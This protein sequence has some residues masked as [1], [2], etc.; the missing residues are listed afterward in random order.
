MENDFWV[1]VV[2]FWAVW[3]FET[4]LLPKVHV[5]RFTDLTS[6][7]R[8]ALADIMKRITTKYDN[9]FCTNFPYSMGWHGR[10]KLLQYNQARR[11]VFKEL[12]L[13]FVLCYRCTNRQVLTSGYE[14][15]GVSWNL[16]PSPITFCQH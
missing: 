12:C 1:A 8:D 7:Q 16:L 13:V 3:P 5:Q 2:P 6:P 14:T 4:M 9:L 10:Y 11:L 15:L